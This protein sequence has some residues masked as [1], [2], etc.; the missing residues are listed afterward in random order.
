[1][2]GEVVITCA[3]TGAGDSVGRHP[4]VPVTPAQ[5]AAAAIEAANAGAAIAHC[6]VR[7][8]ATGKGA[9]DPALYR[10][11]V[12]RIRASGVDVVINLTAGMGGDLEVGEG[13]D[14]R[15][16]LQFRVPRP[17]G[18]LLRRVAIIGC[19]PGESGAADGYRRELQCIFRL[20][21][22]QQRAC[23]Q[24]PRTQQRRRRTPQIAEGANL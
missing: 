9:R 12:E 5:I 4:G 20:S 24:H 13:E 1:M 17:H 21:E 7:D 8:P 16:Q 10:E 2:N 14:G 15:R 18:E 6:H 11:V 3:V 22:G 23:C 19:S